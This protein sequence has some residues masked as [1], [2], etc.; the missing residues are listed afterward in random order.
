MAQGAGPR[1]RPYVGDEMFPELNT[2]QVSYFNTNRTDTGKYVLINCKD[3][4]NNFSRTNPIILNNT[5]KNLLGEV[6]QLKKTK[7]GLFVKTKNQKQTDDLLKINKLLNIE[8]NCM[9]HPTLN[10]I[11]GTAYCPDLTNCDD[12]EILKECAPQG[13]THFRRLKTFKDGEKHDNGLFV[14]HFE[15]QTLPT[16]IKIAMYSLP[17][18]LYIPNPIRCMECQKFG[19]FSDKCQNKGMKICVC[20]KEP[21]KGSPCE[22]NS[23]IC[24]NCSGPHPASARN[25]PYFIYERA[26]NEYKIK[27]KC[28]YIQARNHV[29]Q[30]SLNPEFNSY[31]KAVNDNLQ[32]Q[33]PRN[34]PNKN[35]NLIEEIMKQMIPVFKNMLDEYF[36][37]QATPSDITSQKTSQIPAH[38]PKPIMKPK[39]NT[40]TT[41]ETLER[42]KDQLPVKDN[43]NTNAPQPNIQ[44]QRISQDCAVTPDEEEEDD[45]SNMTVEDEADYTITSRTGFNEPGCKIT[46]T[47]PKHNRSQINKSAMKG[48]L[49]NIG[50]K[51]K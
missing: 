43:K 24:P 38:T 36:Q 30:T 51:K 34:N 48:N 42:S 4:N 44:I 16:N 1:K 9:L 40:S 45:S 7:N 15:R 35:A 50:R 14:F 19:H 31:A 5:I 20:G 3:E 21:H 33:P 18:K 39:E 12:D 29:K 8:I 49:P 23:I 47:K 2:N 41:S 6:Q 17:L 26:V 27:N 28:S 11:K 13:V 22:K 25:C 32:S 37:K 10:Y 46:L